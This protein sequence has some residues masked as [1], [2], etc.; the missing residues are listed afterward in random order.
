M[1][2]SAGSPSVVFVRLYQDICH[3]GSYDDRHDDAFGHT[4]GAWLYTY[5]QVAE[6]QSPSLSRRYGL[7]IGIFSNLAGFL[8]GRD[9]LTMAVV[10]ICAAFPYD[11]KPKY[12]IKS[13]GVDNCRTLPINA[14]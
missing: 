1:D 12:H 5:S 2:A 3:V 9:G 13:R 11:G 8:Y 4:H 7:C 14:L 10:Y 6:L